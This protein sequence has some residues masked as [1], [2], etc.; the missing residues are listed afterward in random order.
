MYEIN[1][2]PWFK[3]DKY[4]IINL[5]LINESEVVTF[6]KYILISTITDSFSLSVSNIFLAIQTASK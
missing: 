1:E 2:K 6:I 5:K 4:D 3:L